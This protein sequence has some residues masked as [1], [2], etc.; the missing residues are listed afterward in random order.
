[1]CPTDD[2]RRLD[3]QLF[4]YFLMHHQADGIRLRAGPRAPKFLL[5]FEPLTLKAPQPGYDGGQAVIKGETEQA[6]SGNS[7]YGTRARG[8]DSR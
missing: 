4:Q 8:N 5:R 6:T 1:M 2:V 7:D 3:L